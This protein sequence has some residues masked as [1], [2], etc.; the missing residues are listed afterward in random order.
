MEDLSN[1]II[2][3]TQEL[4]NLQEQL[5][6]AA[7]QRSD[8]SAQDRVLND[9]LDIGLVQDLKHTVDHMRH[10]L[11][12]YIEFAVATC[13]PHKEV[14]HAQQSER[15]ALITEMLRLLYS[16]S[17]SALPQPQTFVGR[18]TL[19]VELQQDKDLKDKQQQDNH[20]S[21]HASAKACAA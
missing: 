11:W 1:C 7:F 16:S 12:S 18:A 4:K 8:K 13:G 6:W 21:Q 5:Q 17:S 20:D 14:D 9:L 2:R 10:F 19:S 15:L 3:V